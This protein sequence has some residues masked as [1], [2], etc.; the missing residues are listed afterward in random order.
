MP[1]CPDKWSR[2]RT[3]YERSMLAVHIPCSSLRGLRCFLCLQ[4][5]DTFED[6]EGSSLSNIVNG[7]IMLL[8]IGSAV[9]AV[10]ETIPSIHKSLESTWDALET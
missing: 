9:V 2:G 6:P 5:W 3:A 4:I 10:V 8:I 1:F 7:W